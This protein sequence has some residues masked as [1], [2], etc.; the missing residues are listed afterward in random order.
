MKWITY[1][2]FMYLRSLTQLR[3][4]FDIEFCRP[5]NKQIADYFECEKNQSSRK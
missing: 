1:L 4:V 3:N 5:S 2:I